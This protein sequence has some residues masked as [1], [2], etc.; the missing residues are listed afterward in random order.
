MKYTFFQKH[1]QIELKIIMSP[2]LFLKAYLPKLGI[3]WIL[4]SVE[5]FL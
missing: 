4:Q 3:F 2:H 1:G 5:G